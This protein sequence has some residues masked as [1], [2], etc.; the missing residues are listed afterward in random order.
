MSNRSKELL[1]SVL[2]SMRDGLYAG[3]RQ[4]RWLL[5]IIV[6]VSLGVFVLRQIGVL[7]AI[8]TALTP[9]FGVIGLSGTSALAFVAGVL[10]NPYTVVAIIGA[11]GL[12]GREITILS[13]MCLIAHNFPVELAIMKRTGS[14]VIRMFVVRLSAAVIAGASLHALLPGTQA[15]EAALGSAED[16]VMGAVAP[17]SDLPA[18]LGQW[19][20]STL[21]LSLII[22][23]ILCT[24]MICI[25]LLRKLGVIELLAGTFSPLMRVFGLP[26]ETSFLWLVCNLLGLTY[27]AAVLLEEERSGLLTRSDGDLLNHHVAISHSILEDTMVFVAVGA[28][29]LWITVPRVLLAI[30]AVWARRIER[31]LSVRF[32]RAETGEMTE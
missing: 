16:P 12:P 30:A 11:A 17:V 20:V 9:L 15:T 13:V 24:L 25:H 8:S 26:R 10:T 28:P 1:R 19:S 5:S 6:P 14:S 18:A 31:A 32:V 7:A 4:A 21:Q 29:L 3:L 22:T 2:P 23:M 27:G